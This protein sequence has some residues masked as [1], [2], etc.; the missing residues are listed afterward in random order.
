MSTH[1]KTT[2]VSN[3]ATL[4]N[5]KAKGL[6]ANSTAATAAVVCVPP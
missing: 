2:M 4:L 3:V 5:A 6:A 1:S